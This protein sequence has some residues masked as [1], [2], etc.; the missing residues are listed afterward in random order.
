MKKNKLWFLIWIFL[1]FN[2]CKSSPSIENQASKEEITHFITLLENTIGLLIETLD[3]M[4][5]Q[6][7]ENSYKIENLQLQLEQLQK[8]FD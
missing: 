1:F 2:S 5:A 6:I 8:Q 3:R 7:E 4:D